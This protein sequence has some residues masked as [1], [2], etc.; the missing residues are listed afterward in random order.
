MTLAPALL[1]DVLAFADYFGI[2]GFV[3][4]AAGSCSAL[5]AL[6][7]SMQS[8]H[9]RA[10]WWGPRTPPTS[11]PRRPQNEQRS[12]PLSTLQRSQSACS[13]SSTMSLHRS[14]HPSQI[15]ATWPGTGRRTLL[16]RWA[17][18]VQTCL[19]ASG[20]VL[21]LALQSQGRIEAVHAFVA[22]VDSW[23]G[24][25]PASL[26]HPAERTDQVGP[27]RSA[28]VPEDVGAEIKAMVADEY[29]GRT[30]K[31]RALAP[32][33]ERAGIILHAVAPGQGSDH[34]RTPAVK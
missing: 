27:H 33:A 20:T 9:I 10:S 11:F 2:G 13:A 18:M 5:T 30:G 7:R 28:L 4:L 29:R 15:T 21:F 19:L 22:D 32:Q 14:R 17:H 26:V 31:H 6:A 3:P 8:R 23:T 34:R 25:E 12:T 16:S 24:Y 1:D